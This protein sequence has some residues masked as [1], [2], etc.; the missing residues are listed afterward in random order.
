MEFAIRYADTGKLVQEYEVVHERLLH[1]LMTTTD[2]AWF[3]HQHPVRGEDG[4]FRL[5]WTFKRPGKYRL[6]ADF[7]PADGDNQVKPLMLTVGGGAPKT[8]ALRP[9]RTRVKQVGDLRFELKLMGEPPDA[10][11]LHGA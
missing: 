7:T 1:L 4:I 11:Y 5:S 8:V 2:L 6:Y 9:D 10:S 3:E